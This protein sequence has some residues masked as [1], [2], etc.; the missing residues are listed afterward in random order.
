MGSRL[1]RIHYDCQEVTI[2]GKDGERFFL[3]VPV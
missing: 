1:T 3:A 2:K